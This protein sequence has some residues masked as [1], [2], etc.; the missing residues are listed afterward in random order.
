[1]P[2]TPKEFKDGLEPPEA[3]LLAI[4]ERKPYQAYTLGD[5]PVPKTDSL[6]I[7]F[8][9][10]LTLS[11]SLERLVAKRLAQSKRMR[12]DTYYMSSKG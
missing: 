3:E 10:A 2:I 1:M 9:H 11:N 8:G 6:L 7:A 5:F 12:G 4:L